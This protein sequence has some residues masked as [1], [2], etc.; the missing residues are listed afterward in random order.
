MAKVIIGIHG[1]GNKPPY[2]IFKKWWVG[3]LCEGFDRI[4]ARIPFFKFE[5][6][7]WSRYIYATPLDPSIV[8]NEDPLYLEEPYI[9]H[10]P[11]QKPQIVQKKSNRKRFLDYLEKQMD[12]LLI[13]DDLTINFSA[14][15]DLIIHHFFRDLEIYYSEQKAITDSNVSVNTAIQ[16]ELKHMLLKYKNHDILLLAHSMGSII[17]YEALLDLKDQV[18]INTFVTLGSPLGMPVIMGKIFARLKSK[19]P[20]Q[21]QLCV[22][23]NITNS[24]LN[25]SDLDDRVALNYNLADD[26]APNTRNVSIQDYEVHNDYINKE[27]PNPHKLYGYLRTQELAQA[28]A[29]FLISDKAKLRIWIENILKRTIQIFRRY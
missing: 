18:F 17:A 22:P 24:W 25:F 29:Q 14:I 13:N 3:A 21:K 16:N 15:S 8:N 26:F 28:I 10:D 20:N 19:L 5:L 12:K 2:D 23:D 1:L 27:R 6:V 7:Y 11:F 4:G 9:V